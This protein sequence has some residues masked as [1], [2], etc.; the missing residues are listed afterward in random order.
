MLGQH[1][2][3]ILKEILRYGG[4]LR[5]FVPRQVAALLA[6]YR[7]DAAGDGGGRTDDGNS[8]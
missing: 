8:A 3:Q 7:G 1:N 5:E 2:E 6:D 4:D